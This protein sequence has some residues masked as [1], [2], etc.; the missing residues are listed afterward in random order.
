MAIVWCHG[1]FIISI[2]DCTNQILLIFYHAFRNYKPNPQL[3]SWV[4][5]QRK[6]YNLKKRGK[7][8]Y[9]TDERQEQLEAMDFVWS[10]WDY[11]FTLNGFK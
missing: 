5:T 1:K 11:N 6:Y 7:K 10:Y 8:S 9:L 3:A 4:T 2:D